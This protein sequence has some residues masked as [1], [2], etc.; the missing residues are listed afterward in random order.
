MV[1]AVKQHLESK[2]KPSGDAQR[3]QH[4]LCAAEPRNPTETETELCLSVS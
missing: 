2:P 4:T 1:R 3:G